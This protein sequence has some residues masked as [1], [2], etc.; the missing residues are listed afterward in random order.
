MKKVDKIF[1]VKVTIF[2]KFRD[3]KDFDVYGN[4]EVIQYICFIEY[5]QIE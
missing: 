2:E 1:S 3:E 5:D 4:L